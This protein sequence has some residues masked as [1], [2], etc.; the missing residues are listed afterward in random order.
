MLDIASVSV[1]VGI[2]FIVQVIFNSRREDKKSIDTIHKFAKKMKDEIIRDIEDQ[3]V[4]IL[5]ELSE[6]KLFAKSAKEGFRKVQELI[7]DVEREAENVKRYEE[8][9][10]EVKK[11]IGIII[12][13]ADKVNKQVDFFISLRKIYPFTRER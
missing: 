6:I 12:S 9:L 4:K 3:K 5:D 2:S 10:E 1:A 13:N 8:E 11:R 7:D